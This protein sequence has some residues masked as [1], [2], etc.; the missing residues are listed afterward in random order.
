MGYDDSREGL[1]D[2]EKLSNLVMFAAKDPSLFNEGVRDE[3]RKQQ[4]M[5]R[6]EKMIL[7]N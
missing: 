6:L 5:Q 4:W 3:I 1:S 7:G 2:K